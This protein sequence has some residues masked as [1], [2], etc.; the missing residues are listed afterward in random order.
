MH[1]K[2]PE[3][4]HKVSLA[5]TSGTREVM[6]RH[7]QLLSKLAPEWQAQSRVS[8]REESWAGSRE[9]G[10]AFSLSLLPGKPH[11]PHQLLQLSQRRTRGHLGRVFLQQ[12]ASAQLPGVDGPI[13]GG[14][15]PWENAALDM[16]YLSLVPRPSMEGTGATLASQRK[17]ITPECLTVSAQ[18]AALYLG[19][20]CGFSD[21]VI[22][23]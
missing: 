17:G 8:A 21:P 3:A 5:M 10:P 18:P 12:S 9:H 13:L 19:Y 20:L 23:Q 22:L 4:G 11:G 7:P 6:L 14:S 1:P 15:R 16:S 2:L